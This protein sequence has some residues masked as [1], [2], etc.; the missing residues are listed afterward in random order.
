[1]ATVLRRDGEPIV[2]ELDLTEPLQLETPA[3]PLSAFR[4]RH[5]TRL[6]DLLDGLRRGATDPHVVG[7]IA[8]VGV[9]PGL[10][11]AQEVRAAVQAF[12]RSGKPAFAW[13]E[14]FGEFSAGN[15]GY[16]L[17]TGFDQI[18]LGE[19]GDLGLTGVGAEATFLKPALERV[20][21][22]V[23][24][25]QRYE[26]KNA[27]NALTADGFTDAHREAMQRLVE[28]ASDQ[29]ARD[30]AAARG[31]SR[32]RLA[33]LIDA[34][35]LA[36]EDAL[37]AGLIDQIGY[38]DQVHAALRRAVGGR[39]HLQY[40]TR[41]QRSLT[42]EA[43]RLVTER[44]RTRRSG[45]IALIHAT[46]PIRLGRSG[47][48]SPLG[49]HAMGSSTVSAAVRSAVKAD[50]VKAI[51][52]RVD[53]PGGSYAAS[54][55]IRREIVLARA[56]GKPVIVSMGSLAGSGGYFIAMPA[57]VV[58][59]LPATLTGSIGVFGGKLVAEGL[60]DRLG[61]GSGPVAAGAHALMSSNR[62]PYTADERALLDR[63]L[64]RVYADFTAKVAHDRQLDGERVHELAR[65]RVWTGVDAFERGLVDEL[66]GLEVAIRLARE[67]SGLP[68]R[69][70]SG[71]VRLYPRNRPGGRLTPPESSEDIAAARGGWGSFADLASRLGLPA[72]GPLLMPV[73]L[74]A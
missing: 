38:R 9:G 72:A 8:E 21:L 5:R 25:G 50:Q 47:G 66:G 59:A 11:I 65:G 67:R 34:A 4:S 32:E 35:P 29:L 13:A 55:I 69:P 15:S 52:L 62:R 46:G 61:V 26:Y 30:I 12:R 56:A 45:E 24:L 49:G 14:T 60:L 31:L 63:W 33:E 74:T 40:V 44:V 42:N 19:S 20:G 43:T 23:E 41:Y 39:M 10:A 17:A 36:P 48:P 71:D 3:D 37:A 70:D 51:V 73:R 22:Q 54:D 64:D 7:L 27:A 53:S 58:V 68:A 57:D 2:L 28:S 18:W 6:R 16:A 1:M